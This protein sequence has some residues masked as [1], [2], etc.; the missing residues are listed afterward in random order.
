M[1][2]SSFH[3]FDGTKLNYYSWL[4]EKS[5]GT[6]VVFHG[7]AEHGARYRSFADFLN[8]NGY[9]VYAM[10]FRGHGKNIGLLQGH[11]ADRNGWQ[12]V[13]K[14][15]KSFLDFVFNKTGSKKVILLGHSMGSLLL[16]SYLIEFNDSRIS[17]VVLSGTPTAPPTWI[18]RGAIILSEITIILGGKRKPSVLMD[19]LVFGQYS[20][21]IQNPNTIFDWLSHDNDMVL[22]YIADPL[23]GFLCTGS[24]F[25]DLFYG[26][27]HCNLSSNL[28][29]INPKI[30][31]LI[32]SGSEDPAGDFGKAPQTLWNELSSVLEK[33]NTTLI[34][35]Q[36]YRHEILNEVD[37]MR[38]YKDVL[39]FIQK[40]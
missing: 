13:V 23:C 9:D 39:G 28:A 6:V 21:S 25:N 22:K 30:N 27:K 34:V 40:G 8:K 24:F 4:T 29:K 33:G 16:R 32:L 5:V 26:I 19:K 7:M 36:G 1:K 35:Y 17:K 38:V 18:L 37:C 12:I 3:S 2:V 31:I 11:F 14:D 20:K 10:D 15:I